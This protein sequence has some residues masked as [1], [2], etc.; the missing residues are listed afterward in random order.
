MGQ[1]VEGEEGRLSPRGTSQP[2]RLASR[3]KCERWVV[4][5]NEEKGGRERSDSL[6]VGINECSLL[7]IRNSPLPLTVAVHTLSGCAS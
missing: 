4:S 3:L 2:A 6:F 5:R 7:H 1:Y